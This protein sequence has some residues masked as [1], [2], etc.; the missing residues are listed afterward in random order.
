MTASL[1]M[2]RLPEVEATVGLKRS[3]IYE[4]I[5]AGEFPPQVRYVPG[6]VGWRSDQIH[7]WIEA[8]TANPSAAAAPS[9]QQ[10]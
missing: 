4:M 5:K 2:L 8:R 6:A 9:L 10:R 1:R 3:K 7:A